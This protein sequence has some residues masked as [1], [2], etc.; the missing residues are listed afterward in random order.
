MPF[1]FFFFF[2]W[3]QLCGKRNQPSKKTRNSDIGMSMGHES[4]MPPQ[5]TG[6]PIAGKR[7]PG[8]PPPRK[9]KREH[10]DHHNGDDDGLDSSDVRRLEQKWSKPLNSYLHTIFDVA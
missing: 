1:F 8:P 10:V 6:N 4:H 2:R 3:A 5:I 9:R 7:T